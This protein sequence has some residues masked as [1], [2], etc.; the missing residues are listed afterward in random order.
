MVPIGENRV[1]VVLK[2]H[3]MKFVVI[4]V[5]TFYKILKKLAI[6]VTKIHRLPGDCH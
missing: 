3:V 6:C 2:F 5:V 1:Q 4:G